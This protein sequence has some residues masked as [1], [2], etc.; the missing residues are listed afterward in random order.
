MPGHPAEGVRAPEREV[1]YVLDEYEAGR[2]PLGLSLTGD[3]GERAA[4]V[5]ARAL[6]GADGR[7]GAA[8]IDALRQRNITTVQALDELTARL[9][10]WRGV[11]PLTLTW[12]STISAELAEAHD[13]DG[14]PLASIDMTSSHDDGGSITRVDL[15]QGAA[16]FSFGMIDMPGLPETLASQLRGRPLRELLTHP[17]LDAHPFTIEVIDNSPEN[18]RVTVSY[19]H[20]WIEIRAVTTEGLAVMAREHRGEDA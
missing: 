2:D 20:Q 5:V 15:G 14:T 11:D 6:R 19:E 8:L 9:M 13:A 17:V 18:A 4:E 12:L 1:G 3:A 10:L 7:T 16:W